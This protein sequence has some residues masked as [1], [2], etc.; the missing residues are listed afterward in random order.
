MLLTG[1]TIFLGVAL[2]LCKLPR[3]WM[4]RAL[5]YDVAL[6]LVVSALT[7]ALHFG[8][9]SGLMAATVAGLLCSVATS[10]AKKLF[11]SIDGRG[12]YVPGLFYLHVDPQHRSSLP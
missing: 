6:D 10:G 11:G 4:L 7:L 8:T 2:I 3:R 5:Y 12:N 1:L 9:F